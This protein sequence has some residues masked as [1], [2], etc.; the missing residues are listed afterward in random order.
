MVDR[1]RLMQAIMA[2]IDNSLKFTGAGGTIKVTVEEQPCSNMSMARMA[3]TIKDDGIGMSEEFKD[4]AFDAFTKEENAL[5]ANLTG[6]G[7][8]LTIT[9]K[10]VELMGGYVTLMSKKNLG[11]EVTMVLDCKI[12]YN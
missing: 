5:D 10:L 2:V 11:T 7:L 4:I 12:S 6:V 8:G 9:K 3:I 1:E